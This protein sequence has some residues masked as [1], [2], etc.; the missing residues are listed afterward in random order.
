[1]QFRINGITGGMMTLLK[2][3]SLLRACFLFL[4]ALS[5]CKTLAHPLT[6]TDQKLHSI[7]EEARDY[8][9]VKPAYSLAI[10]ESNHDLVT[11]ASEYNRFMYYRTG[12]WVAVHLYDVDKISSFAHAMLQNRTFSGSKHHFHQLLNSMSL[13]F[14]VNQNYAASIAAGRCAIK[15]SENEVNAIHNSV[16][17]ALTL[18]LQGK[19]LEAQRIFEMNVLMNKKSENKIGLAAAKNNLGLLHVFNGNYVKAN[20]NFRAALKLNEE[21]ARATG[22]A[23]NLVNLLLVFYLQQDWDNFYRLS[24]RANRASK[25]L[26][27]EDLKQ[28]VL[29]VNSAFKIKTQGNKA[30]YKGALIASYNKVKEPTVLKIM[31][32]LAQNLEIT[33]PQKIQVASTKNIDFLQ[34]FPLC[35]SVSK[36]TTQ[37]SKL[38]EMKMSKYLSVTQLAEKGDANSP[39]KI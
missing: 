29:W 19:Y 18:L 26:K 21:M 15:F 12:F 36:S 7:I 17:P 16:S 1:M 13:W 27:N 32:M 24:A 11:N 33:L 25:T 8:S 28:Y 14:R 37:I 38:L 5:C 9:L 35:Q 4:V 31:T 20:T 3:I 39:T 10:L 2:S 22:T 30:N 23:L 34:V 6:N